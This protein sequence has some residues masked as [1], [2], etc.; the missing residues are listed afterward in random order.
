[1]KIN[2]RSNKELPFLA[3]LHLFE[4]KR[5]G[6]LLLPA[7][8]VIITLLLSC[9]GPEGVFAIRLPEEDVYRRAQ[10]SMEIPHDQEVSWVYQFNRS[11]NDIIGV[12]IKKKEIVW[13]EIY[14]STA[15]VDPGRQV[16]YGTIKDLEPGTYQILLTRITDGNEIIDRFDFTVYARVDEEED[17]VTY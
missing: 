6:S 8:T 12:I 15:R 14:N 10:G 16:V 13:V 2:T 4:K 5:S 11:T 7:V 9:G 1:M 3:T 17:F